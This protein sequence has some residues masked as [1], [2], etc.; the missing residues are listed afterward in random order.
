MFTNRLFVVLNICVSLFLATLFS[1]GQ[2]AEEIGDLFENLEWRCVGP[3]LMGGRT[4]DID[5]VEKEPW[6]IYTAIGPSGVWKSDNNG[7]T[8]KPVFYKEKTVSVGDIAIAQSHPDIIWV[9]TGEATSRNSVTIGDGVYKSTDSGKTWIN[10]GLEDTRHISRIVI[11]P[12]DPNIVFVA[13]MGHLWGPNQER[14]VY[15]T[16]DGGKTWRKVLYIDENTGFA[17]LAMHPADSLTLYAAAYEHRRLP[18]YF[19]SGGPGSGLYKSTDGGETWKKLT[20]DLPEGIMGRIGI[21]V[22]RSKPDVVYAL[23]EH[24]DGG[25]WRSEDRGETWARTCDNETYERINFRPFYYSQIRVDPSDDEVVYVFSGGTY[26]SKDRGAKFRAISSGTHPDHHA[27][28]IDPQNPL[29]LIDGNDGGIDITYDGG[30]T[31]QDIQHMALAEVY[32]V[33]FDMR[34]PYYVYCGLQDNG[35]WGGPSATMDTQGITNCDWF[36]VGYGDGFYAQ[37]DPSDY[38]IIYGNSQMNG[39][40]RYDLRIKKSKSIKPIASLQNLPYRFNWNSPIHIS[41]HDPKTV[42]TGG[43]YLFKTTDG[44]QK[45]EVISPDLS[46]DDPEKQKDSGG[47]ITWDNTGAEIHCTII[48]ISES[49]VAKGVIWCGTD[50]GNVQVTR[51][52]GKTWENVVKNIPGLPANTWCSRIEASHFEAGTAYAA[53]DGHRQNDYGTYV[54]KTT[55]YG[56]TWSS[57]RGNLPFGWVHVVREDLKNR[58]LLYVGTEFNIYA[59]L[60]RGRTWF[61]LRNNLPTVAVRDI[62]VHPRDNDLIIGTH[63]RG[64]WILDD[65]VSLQ[66]MNSEIFQ[67]DNYLFSL[68]PVTLYEMSSS[69]ESSSLPVYAADNPDIGVVFY[70]YFKVKPKEKPKII[71]KDAQGDQVYEMSIPTKEG[72]LRQVWNLQ[73]VPETKEGKKIKPSGMGLVALPLVFPAEYSVEMTVDGETTTRKLMIHPDPRLAM[74]KK[75]KQSQV[76]AQAEIIAISKKMGLAV[77]AVNRI[78]SQLQTLDKA[79]KEKEGL[80]EELS[81]QV[82]T[83]KE[84]FEKVK[85]EITPERFGYKVS[86]E[87]ALRGGSIPQ[88]ILMLGMSLGS[89]PAAPTETDWLQIRELNK[90]ADLRVGLINQVILVDMPALNKVLEQYGLKPMKVPDKV[91]LE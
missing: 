77:T 40:Y 47:P 53:F 50:D 20:K 19:S 1:Y 9:G 26:V 24:Q 91:E 25:I 63:G 15:K 4:V 8:W 71:I 35:V 13:A 68:R 89:F 56:K 54:Y 46:T 21:D 81:L 16:T 70:T 44:G 85:E 51:D 36:M 67:S 66:E 87:T 2:S 61:S 62:A 17:D 27:L 80:P 23:I 60:D 73:Y 74:D 3:A 83:F 14:G 45:W 76:E 90:E 31:W 88:Q 34:S 5:V 33:G 52:G 59:S 69:G 41:P 55:D 42:Y 57:L 49:P 64:I 86:M 43:N 37:V 79:L 11:N 38:N 78:R 32:Q 39:L 48:T 28:W 30:R 58:D 12:G 65:I 82:K 75:E 22:A 84:T 72:L 6:I 7:T 10:M 18:F 29:H